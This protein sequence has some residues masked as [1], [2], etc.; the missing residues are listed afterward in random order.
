[1]RRQTPLKLTREARHMTQ[2]ELATRARISIAWLRILE[3][4]TQP[5]SPKLV[6]RLARAL[7]V[8]PDALW[9]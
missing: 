3:R 6:A 9:R 8:E 4:R 7:G 5:P 1:M 2:Q